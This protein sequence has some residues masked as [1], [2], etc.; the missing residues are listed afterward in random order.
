MQ[1]S[2]LLNICYKGKD[3]IYEEIVYV[4]CGLME[5]WVHRKFHPYKQLLKYVMFDFEN[6]FLLCHSLVAD[7]IFSQNFNEQST[8]SKRFNCSKIVAIFIKG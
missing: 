7:A 1:K 2:C 6:N 3:N 8:C 4:K 5:D